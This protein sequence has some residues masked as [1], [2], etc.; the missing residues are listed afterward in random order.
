M[1]SIYILKDAR[2]PNV[3]K[4]GM[5]ET[6]T[7]ETRRK[8]YNRANQT[9]WVL[10]K[11]IEVK[12]G[13]AREFEKRTHKALAYLRPE[14]RIEFFACPPELALSVIDG[15]ISETGKLRDIEEQ[16]EALAFDREVLRRERAKTL[17][18]TRQSKKQAGELEKAR[19][20]YFKEFHAYYPHAAKEAAFYLK[21]KYE[22]DMK[23]A[24]F[25]RYVFYGGMFGIPVIWFFAA[26]AASA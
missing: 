14:P 18:A 2:D 13:D 20:E 19:K 5:T 17:Q 7:A 1:P 16:R 10:F 12:R 9:R 24:K 11:E 6:Q 22:S 23:F 8:Q 21:E 25:G 3:C 26:I 4:I 15:V